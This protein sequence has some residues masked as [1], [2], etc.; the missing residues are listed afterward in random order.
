[1]APVEDAYAEPNLLLKGR[2]DR[3]GFIEV[4]PPGGIRDAEPRTSRAAIFG[5]FDDDGGIDVVVVNIGAPTRLLRNVV[6][7]RGR[8][9]L[10]DVRDD[11]GAP[12][13]GA[14]VVADLDGRRLTR[15][16]RTDSSYLAA[17]DPRAHFGL[18]DVAE[19]PRLEITWPDGRSATLESVAAD[20]V[21]RVAPVEPDA[22]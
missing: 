17:G 11:A 15:M 5:D 22:G 19:V 21:V 3:V 14:K 20:R 13:I 8:W 1:M 12:A 16:V 6:P 7:S 18:G 2:A 10:V 4:E 9:L